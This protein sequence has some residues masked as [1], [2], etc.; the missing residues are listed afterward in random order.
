[1]KRN[2]GMAALSSF[3]IIS[4]HAEVPESA[5]VGFI[6]C[7]NYLNG[8]LSYLTIF[9]D[10]FLLIYQVVCYISDGKRV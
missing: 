5:L 4:L 9:M 6:Y 1:M 10:S 8:S 2:N 3:L 7:C